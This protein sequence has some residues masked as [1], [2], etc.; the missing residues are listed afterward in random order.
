[1]E[2]PFTC[3]CPYP[4]CGVVSEFVAPSPHDTGPVEAQ[5]CPACSKAFSPRSVIAVQ[6]LLSAQL[7]H[8][9][10]R[11]IVEAGLAAAFEEQAFS[12]TIDAD[13]DKD[14]L[15]VVL[16]NIRSLHNVGA[17]FRTADAAGFSRL[18]LCGMTGMPP[19]NEI[20]KVS[21]G[22]ETWMPFNYQ[23][24]LP[25]VVMPLKEKGYQIVALEKCHD[26]TGLYEALE[27]KELKLPLALI[28]GNEVGG[29]SHEGVAM[30]DHVCHLSMRGKKESL[31]VSVAFGV[32]SYFLAE[33]LL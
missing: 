11:P 9:I 32:A 30:A 23:V 14:R 25:S 2:E 27:K 16:D 33:Y 15:I 7:R 29:L 17:I 21:L 26:S 6:K 13:P 10:H 18:Y 24:F 12:S 31:N 20:A 22:A 3:Q 4:D 5:N 1:L 19:R 8:K 28:V